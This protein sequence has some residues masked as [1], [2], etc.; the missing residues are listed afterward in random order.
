MKSNLKEFL[1]EIVE[2]DPALRE[3]EEELIPLIE[4][5]LASDPAQAPSKE[6]V[7][8]LRSQLF[9]SPSFDSPAS[10]MFN[11]LYYIIGPVAIAAVALPF[12]FVAYNNSNSVGAPLFTQSITETDDQAF[13][14]LSDLAANPV[15]G[16]GGGGE[17]SRSQSGGGGGGMGG[18]GGGAVS[19]DSGSTALT[20]GKMIAPYP[21]TQFTYQYDGALPELAATVGVF[22]RDPKSSAQSWS[23]LSSRFNLGGINLNS[24]SGMN[25]DNITLTQHTSFGY[26]LNLNLR[27]STLG[28]DANWEQWPM[29]KCQDEACWRRERVTIGDL[30]SDEAAIGIASDFASAHGIDLANYGDPE[31]NNNWRIEYERMTDKTYAYVPDTVQVI[32]PLMID[33]KPVHDQQGNKYGMTIGVHA[34][35]KRVMN[36]WGITDRTYLKSDYAGV[37]DAAS[38]KQFLGTIDQWYTDPA[39]MV[40][41]GMPAPQKAT[42][43]LG[44]PTLGYA[45]YNRYTVGKSE[46]L[47]VPSLLFP[48]K[49]VQGAKDANPY[50]Q[51]VVVPLAQE[52]L[53][54]NID[55]GVM[56][57]GGAAEDLVR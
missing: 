1:T 5:L 48:I 35:Y 23:A 44:E 18:G 13:G 47:L 32:F 42:V 8:R 30:P 33:G 28:I 25:V 24:F 9:S 49:E 31:V 57:M 40:R 36:V 45:V 46:E 17:M 38:I 39:A 27:D 19:M 21:M 6:F 4:K 51:T 20:A 14:A 54:N 29:S 12:A 34:K 15:G 7:A 55:G 43:I 26:M 50:R 11:K 10:P 16:M 2:I 53:N 56:P 22:K 52:M 3:H 37:T 41:E